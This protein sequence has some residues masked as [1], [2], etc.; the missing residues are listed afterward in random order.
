MEI[1]KGIPL[2]SGL[3]GS[4]ASAVGAVV[5]ANALLRQAAARKLELLKFAMQGE[6]VASGSLHVDNI[7]PSPVRR[8]RAHRRHRQSAREADSGAAGRPRGHRPS[9]HVPVDEAGA[10]HPQPH[11]RDVGLRLA[12]RESR[13]LHLRLLHQ[14]S[15]HDPRVVRRRGH[16]AAASGAD[17]RLSPKC[18]R[19]SMAAGALGCSISGAGPTMFAWA[20]GERAPSACATPCVREFATRS[21]RSRRVDRATSSPPARASC[22]R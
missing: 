21:H 8:P 15:R 20:A 3:G 10:R 4:A 18:A 9:A 13:R 19:A 17:S 11:R 5:A 12:D 22:R 2:G 7:S 1:D 16:R 14:R 6:A